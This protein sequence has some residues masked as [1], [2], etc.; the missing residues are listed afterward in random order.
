MPKHYA[1]GQNVQEYEVYFDNTKT[2]TLVYDAPFSQRPIVQLTMEDTGAVP[3]YKTS[4]TA[5]G[6]TIKFKTPFIGTVTVL[7]MAKS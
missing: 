6:C 7:V 3:A 5:T 2:A 4:V 1:V